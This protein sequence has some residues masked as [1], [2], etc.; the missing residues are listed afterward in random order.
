MPSPDATISLVQRRIADQI[1][2]GTIQKRARLELFEPFNQLALLA[3]SSIPTTLN[4][5]SAEMALFFRANRDFIIS[6]AGP[7]VDT[8]QA[9]ADD[10]GMLM[11]T[12]SAAPASGNSTYITPHPTS[13]TKQSAWGLTNRFGSTKQIRL[14]AQVSLPSIDLVI[15]RVGL[16]AALAQPG[17]IASTGADNNAIFLIF[18]PALGANWQLVQNIA[19]AD[20]VTDTG[21][22]VTVDTE[23]LID[24]NIDLGLKT[25]IHINGTLIAAGLLINSPVNMR[26]QIAVGTLTNAAKTIKIRYMHLS[27]GI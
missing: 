4:P 21:V 2:F 23:Y 24:F 9:F 26:P 27:T 25:I 20:T 10:G 5:T 17:N 1:P 12:K 15:A 6:G 8:N 22:V 16:F 13:V 19:G 14:R 11:S 3:A 18:D 7:P